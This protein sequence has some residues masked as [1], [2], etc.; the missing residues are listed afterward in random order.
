MHVRQDVAPHR[1]G[2]HPSQALAVAEHGSV[3][4]IF[5]KPEMPY[6]LGLLGSMPRLDAQP[7]RLLAIEGM[8]PAPFALP[9]GCRWRSAPRRRPTSSP[10]RA[11]RAAT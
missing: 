8:V 4:D 2:Q 11:T 10:A 5:H 6:T 3:D 7:G 1:V 9:A